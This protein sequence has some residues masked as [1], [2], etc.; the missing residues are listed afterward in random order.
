MAYDFEIFLPRSGDIG[1][2]GEE[3]AD[4]AE[5]LGEEDESFSLD[6][7]FADIFEDATTSLGV[8]KIDT[9]LDSLEVLRYLDCLYETRIFETK[10]GIFDE[11]EEGIR[12]L[13]MDASA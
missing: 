13:E 12:F 1:D 3:D 10:E 8:D 4:L 5:G 11:F 6:I 7:E 9:N 2:V